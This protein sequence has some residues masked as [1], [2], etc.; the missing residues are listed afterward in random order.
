MASGLDENVCDCT[1]DRYLG[2]QIAGV[3]PFVVI[4]AE[5]TLAQKLYSNQKP[6]GGQREIV[7]VKHEALESKIFV[8]S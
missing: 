2:S 4:C 1:A 5:T 7:M 6:G 8:I 3:Y